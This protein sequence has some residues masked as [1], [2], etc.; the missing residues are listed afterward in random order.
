MSQTTD[1][2]RGTAPVLAAAAA[3]DR[4]AFIGYLP[5]G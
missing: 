5:V 1:G 2:G 4:A 3:E